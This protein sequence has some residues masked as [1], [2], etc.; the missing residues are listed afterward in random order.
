MKNYKI[1]FLL[2]LTMMGQYV[3]AQTE[4][5]KPKEVFELFF[6]L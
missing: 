4:V 5:K 6:G 2:L 3:S 1:I